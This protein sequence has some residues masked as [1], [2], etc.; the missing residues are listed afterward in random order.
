M[1]SFLIYLLV[2]CNMS[3]A[4]DKFIHLSKSRTHFH[5]S[6]ALQESL[7][8]Q[9]IQLGIS[10]KSQ[11]KFCVQ[12]QFILRK[13]VS[14]SYFCWFVVPMSSLHILPYTKHILH[15]YKLRKKSDAPPCHGEILW[16]WEATASGW[17]KEVAPTTAAQGPAAQMMGNFLHHSPCPSSSFT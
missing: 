6:L 8:V 16:G 9:W 10:D 4:G 12:F 14:A 2:D 3:S 1:I 5:S 11:N 15:F 13:L 7:V 17:R